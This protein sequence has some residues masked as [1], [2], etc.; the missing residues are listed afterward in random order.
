MDLI[1]TSAVKT[2]WEK[3]LLVG[4]RVLTHACRQDA[5]TCSTKKPSILFQFLITCTPFSSPKNHTPLFLFEIGVIH[6]IRVLRRQGR[7]E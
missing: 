5:R 3:H 4:K 7:M 6:R 2:S 1:K